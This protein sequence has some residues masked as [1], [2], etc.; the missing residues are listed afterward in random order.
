MLK[1]KKFSVASKNP[2]NCTLYFQ[3]AFSL[4]H[5]ILQGHIILKKNKKQNTI[6][7]LFKFP[8]Y[9]ASFLLFS[10]FTFVKMSLSLKIYSSN[11]H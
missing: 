7:L 3:M 2:K 6:C 4:K 11:V 8:F 9:T 10:Y 1:M 5:K